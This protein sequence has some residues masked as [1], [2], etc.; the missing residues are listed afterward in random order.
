M[1]TLFSG[2]HNRLLTDDDQPAIPV[3]RFVPG[4][5]HTSAGVSGTR[6]VSGGDIPELARDAKY[7]RP[8]LL[9]DY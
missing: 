6:H 7:R 9:A 3:G 4:L 8:G 5:E 2:T 1:A